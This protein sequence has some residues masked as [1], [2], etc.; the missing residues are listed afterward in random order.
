MNCDRVEITPPGSTECEFQT[1]PRIS[2]VFRSILSQVAGYQFHFMLNLHHSGAVFVTLEDWS[3]GSGEN[4]GRATGEHRKDTTELKLGSIA[5]T[6]NDTLAAT[7]DAG[8][9]L[10]NA[11]KSM[12]LRMCSAYNGLIICKV[13]RGEKALAFDVS[14]LDE[15]V[16]PQNQRHT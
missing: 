12:S 2:H 7:I 4:Q 1:L 9:N 14:F 3:L 11:V 5:L 13:V 8:C 16:L 10:L 6:T 15:P